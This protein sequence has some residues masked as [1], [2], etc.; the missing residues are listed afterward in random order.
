MKAKISKQDAQ[1]IYEKMQ[2]SFDFKEF[3]VGM[4]VE[5]EHIDVTHGNLVQTAKITAAHL[6]ENPKYYSLLLK[7]VEKKP[8]AK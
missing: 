3:F 8:Q 5:L 7:Y 1:T 4:N 2:Y 6:N